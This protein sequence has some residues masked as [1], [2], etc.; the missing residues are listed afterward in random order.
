MVVRN[1]WY[2]W[3]VA[4]P[5]PSLRARLKWH[6]ITLLLAGIR[7]FN[8]F[9]LPPDKQAFTEASGRCYAWFQLL[10][11]KPERRDSRKGAQ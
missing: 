9:S 1:G 2:V 7:L 4:Y 11:S 10:F 8:S 6:A 3:R 5:K